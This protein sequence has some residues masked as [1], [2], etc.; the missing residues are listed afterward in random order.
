PRYTAL[1]HAMGLLARAGRL[2]GGRRRGGR[3]VV[4]TRLPDHEVIAAA[5]HA[6]P[7]L[8]TTPDA[9]RRRALALPP[10]SALAVVSGEAAEAFVGDVAGIEVRG[11][12]DGMWQLRADDHTALGNALAAVPRPPGRLRIEVDP[13]RV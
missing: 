9:E 2:V 6:D 10:Y 11:P 12:V 13:R 5:L 1:E 7:A 3:V 8:V 4:Q